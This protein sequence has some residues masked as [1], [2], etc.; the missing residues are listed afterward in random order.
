MGGIEEKD[1][2]NAIVDG[3]GSWLRGS[4][5]FTACLWSV[6][7][8]RDIP[9]VCR[10]CEFLSAAAADPAWVVGSLSIDE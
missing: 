1:P 8:S 5:K 2:T 4:D 6:Q 10:R 7:H 3:D 9:D